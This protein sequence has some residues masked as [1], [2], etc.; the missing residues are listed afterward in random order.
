MLNS[1]FIKSILI[2]FLSAFAFTNGQTND[3]FS[4]QNRL[5]FGNSLFY[6][7]DYLRAIG[8]FKS[9]L[10]SE[11][12]DTV[13]FKMAFALSQMGRH[14]EAEDNFKGLFFTPDLSEEAKLEYF[15]S[16]FF[17]N[18]SKM[19]LQLINNSP[20]IPEKYERN[21][22]QLK[23]ISMLTEENSIPDTN[24]IKNLFSEIEK[25]E[26]MKFYFRKVNPEMK[27]PE[28][29][30]WLSAIIPGLGKIYAGEIGDGITSFLFTGVLSFLAYD[31]FKADHKFRAWL[32]TGLAAW[33]YG[34]N[35]YGSAA[36][37]Q[38]YNAGVKYGFDND[39]KIYLNSKNYYLP[40]YEFLNK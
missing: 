38:N 30:A 17:R 20:F 18:D 14:I 19:F 33:F 22:N 7:K 10:N 6:Q 21:I 5:K 37:A 9:Y 28:T 25:I 8:E 11:N 34:G 2:V 15:K 24:E 3:I 27:S 16:N 39:L 40:E 23:Q 13:K 29:A 35:I 32:F 26:L 4:P 31:N 1:N 12:N 36:A